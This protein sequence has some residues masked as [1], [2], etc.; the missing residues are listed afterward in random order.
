MPSM[1]DGYSV[2]N[3]GFNFAYF[4][5]TYTQVSI[6][7]NGYVCMGDNSL[8]GQTSR[9]APHEILVGLN[10][11]LDT[12][13]S[14]SGQIYFKDTSPD[15]SDFKSAKDYVNL[16]NSMFLP[17]NVFVIAYDNVLPYNTASSSRTNFTIFLLSDNVNS[18]AIF[19]YVSCPTDL[20]V[21]SLSGLNH[22]NELGN[23]QEI[24][25]NKGQ[26]CTSSNVNQTGLWV[27]NNEPNGCN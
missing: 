22:K 16:L 5:K 15:S 17:T 14:G 7:S 18:Y 10:Y 12:R 23:L 26:E 2:V 4:R 27:W 13:R 3:L 8:C 6:S 21:N 25:I 11:D 19:K 9:P 1:D 24:S 20:S